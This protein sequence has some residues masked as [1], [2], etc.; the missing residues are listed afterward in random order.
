MPHHSQLVTGDSC[1]I[2]IRASPS[3][4][5]SSSAAFPSSWVVG[6]F[7]S[8][9]RAGGPSSLPTPTT[10]VQQ[11]RPGRRR[12]LARPN[13]PE[14]LSTTAHAT[15][16]EPD[17][18]DR[19]G[20]IVLI[21]PSRPDHQAARFVGPLSDAP[22][23]A[24]NTAARSLP[25]H[26]PL[27]HQAARPSLGQPHSDRSPPSSSSSPS[28]SLLPWSSSSLP[29]SSSHQII[30]IPTLPRDGRIIRF[31]RSTALSIDLIN[32]VASRTN[33]GRPHAP[34]SHSTHTLFSTRIDLGLVRKRRNERPS[35]GDY[36]RRPPPVRPARS[37]I[38]P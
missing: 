14:P 30:I 17:G 21:S 34:F 11:N 15:G 5:P 33:K 18:T 32:R 24:A 19:T 2:I 27:S 35:F 28:S 26:A 13:R 6:A 3:L 25:G 22:P 1:I 10:P 31:G 36:S 7:L 37:F 9:V 8:H 29:S 16:R 4:S 38:N 20:R 12:T 23:N